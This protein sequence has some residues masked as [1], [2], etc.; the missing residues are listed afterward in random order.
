M[1]T[2]NMDVVSYV[3]KVNGVAI[4]ESFTSSMAA[5][6][7]KNNLP[8]EQRTLAEVVPVTTDGKTL[9]LG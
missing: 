3:I 2:R 1:I 7:A 5:E 6:L 4:S 8:D 9:L